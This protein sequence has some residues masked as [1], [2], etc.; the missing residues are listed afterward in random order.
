[1]QKRL[2]RVQ[3]FIIVLFVAAL[4]YFGYRVVANQ[5]DGKLRASGTI[6]AVEVDVSPETSGKIKEVL[7]DEGQTVKMGEP[8][9][10]LDDSRPTSRCGCPT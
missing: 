8:L 2:S 4:A 10:R 7:A 5:D 1:M 6:E 9:L 3:I